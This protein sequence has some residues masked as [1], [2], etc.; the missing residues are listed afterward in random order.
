[1]NGIVRRLEDTI[2]TLLSIYGHVIWWIQNK[3]ARVKWWWQV[4]RPL[5]RNEFDRCLYLDSF[6]MFFLSREE[7][8]EYIADIAKRR[9]RAH[10]RSL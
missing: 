8:G 6:T 2:Y 10:E 7:R 9:N 3:V 4:H 5:P 1:M